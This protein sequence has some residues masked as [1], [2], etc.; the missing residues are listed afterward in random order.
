MLR[1]LG[2]QAD[3]GAWKKEIVTERRWQHGTPNPVGTDIL[4]TS[5]YSKRPSGTC[6]HYQS[7]PCVPRKEVLTWARFSMWVVTS[8]QGKIPIQTPPYHCSYSTDKNKQSLVWRGCRENAL[9]YAA[10]GKENRHS[11]L[12]N[13]LVA[14]LKY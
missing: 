2:E 13:G 11:P 5:K 9:T 4:V 6:L 7:H 3:C 10:G 8:N 14:S 1:C 12:E